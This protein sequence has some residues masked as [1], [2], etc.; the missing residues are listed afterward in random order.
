MAQIRRQ[1]SALLVLVA[2]VASAC[3]SD[4][5]EVVVGQDADDASELV[6][7]ASEADAM[8][9]D[10]S[11]AVAEDS[12]PTEV[13][14][15]PIDE[16][17]AAYFEDLA[18]ARAKWDEAGIE[19]YDFSAALTETD[20]TNVVQIEV[21]GGEVVRSIPGDPDLNIDFPAFPELFEVVRDEYGDIES[22]SYDDQ[23]GYPVYVG[24][25][26][27]G[28]PASVEI[29]RFR[30][31]EDYPEGCPTSPVAVPD[32][33]DPVSETQLML[34]VAAMECDW[35]TLAHLADQGDDELVTSFGGDGVE[36]LWQEDGDL[37]LGTLAELLSTPAT[38]IEGGITVWPQEYAE[39]DEYLGH[40]VGIDADGE[41]LFFVA[42]D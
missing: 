24:G 19:D 6:E 8:S 30:T 20:G 3:S 21:R 17:Q 40:R 29:Y 9:G 12:A 14:S 4:P 5:N 15:D 26:N 37:L 32:A 28:E 23:L 22:V 13:F 34:L 18:V 16:P 25:D 1:V 33:V 35:L 39:S 27:G 42:G 41:W 11:A 38:V 7:D 31:V 10:S 2:L 36:L